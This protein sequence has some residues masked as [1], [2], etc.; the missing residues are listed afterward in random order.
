ML[1]VTLAYTTDGSKDMFLLPEHVF[2]PF[3]TEEKR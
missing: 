2:F 1:A 3:S